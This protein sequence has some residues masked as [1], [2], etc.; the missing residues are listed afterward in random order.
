MTQAE[1]EEKANEMMAY[2]VTRDTEKRSKF[3]AGDLSEGL[4]G[5][6]EPAP[7]NAKFLS[8]MQK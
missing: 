4:K 5:E 3:A 6:E 2:A 8:T 1:K 7:K